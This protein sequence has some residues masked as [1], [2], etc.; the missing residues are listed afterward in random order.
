MIELDNVFRL[1]LPKRRAVDV[2][3]ALEDVSLR[4]AE[5][6]FVSLVGPSGCGKSTILNLIAGF[7]Q[8]TEGTVRMRGQPVVTLN[9]ATG[10]VTQDDTLFPWRTTRAN[11][12]FALEVRGVATAARRDVVE[13]LL[14]QVGLQGFENHYPHEL[15]GGMRKRA[16][17]VRT[18]AYEP[19]ILLMDE[20]FGALDAQTK[21]LLQDQLLRI[22]EEQRR[23][24]L[25]V[26]HDLVEAIALSDR[27]LVMSRAPGRILAEIAVDIPRPRDVFH[28]HSNPAFPGLYERVWEHLSKELG[29]A[30]A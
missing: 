12:E 8:P 19:E 1:F 20:P 29:A 30:R 9:R 15:S 22:W 27:V 11:V 5:G 10:Y 13:R 2:F 25:F 26:T 16:A 18:L 24:V 6:E 14:A 4:V 17:I 3:V 7:L 28:I 21:L 23:T